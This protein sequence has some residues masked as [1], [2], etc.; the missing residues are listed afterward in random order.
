MKGNYPYAVLHIY[1]T[2]G[3]KEAMAYA[4][5]VAKEKPSVEEARQYV[6][7]VIKTNGRPDLIDLVE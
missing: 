7:D 5:R 3:F 2:K 4:F 1:K 6:R